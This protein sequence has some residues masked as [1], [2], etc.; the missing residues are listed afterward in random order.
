MSGSGWEQAT[1]PVGSSAVSA[2]AGDGY[3]LIALKPLHRGGEYFLVGLLRVACFVSQ[4]VEARHL[5]RLL[6]DWVEVSDEQG[7]FQIRQDEFSGSGGFRYV[8]GDVA[9]AVGGDRLGLLFDDQRAV[10]RG[11]RLVVDVA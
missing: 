2:I 8:G 6:F 1:I 9:I 4:V 7:N 5:A 11:S 10:H 3:L